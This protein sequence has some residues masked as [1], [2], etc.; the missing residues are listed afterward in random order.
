MQGATDSGGQPVDRE[1]YRTF[2]GLQGVFQQPYSI[3][4]PSAWAAATSS[5]GKV[6][7]EFRK[8]VRPCGCAAIAEEAVRQAHGMFTGIELLADSEG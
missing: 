4:E 1:F 2:W 6:L 7:A 3:M 8:Q 5:I